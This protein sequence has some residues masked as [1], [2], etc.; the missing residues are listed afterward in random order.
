MCEVAESGRG[1]DEKEFGGDEARASAHR[2]RDLSQRRRQ[3][4]AGC[5]WVCDVVSA[6]KDYSPILCRG[7]YTRRET[8]TFPR[9]GGRATETRSLFSERASAAESARRRRPR[10]QSRAPQSPWFDTRARTKSMRCRATRLSGAYSR[11]ASY[12]FSASRHRRSASYASPKLFHAV[13]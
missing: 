2:E 5:V 10:L 8:R 12:A 6:P 11:A 1:L 13:T 9:A 7:P 3:P 4:T